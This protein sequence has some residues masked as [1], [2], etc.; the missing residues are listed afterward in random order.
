MVVE[1]VD[2]V[3][4]QDVA[5]GVGEDSGLELPLSGLQDVLEVK[6]SGDTVLGGVQGEFDDLG[7]SHHGLELSVPLELLPALGAHLT[8]LVGVAS[9]PAS[10]Y[11]GVR[12]EE[13][14]HGTDRGGLG[15]SLASLDEDSADA[16]VDGVQEQCEFHVFLSDDAGEGE[17]V[18]VFGHGI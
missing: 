11:D 18:V 17:G 3:D 13:L 6:G 15:G 5:V 12:G 8:D 16:G 2:L 4:V 1:E 9:E 14:G 7:G 10:L